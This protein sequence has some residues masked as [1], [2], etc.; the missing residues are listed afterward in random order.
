ML[1]DSCRSGTHSKKL[2]TGL[3]Q[4]VNSEI[5][6]ADIGKAGNIPWVLG[7]VESPE[8]SVREGCKLAQGAR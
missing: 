8:H 1:L 6:L 4:A 5:L 2:I 3:W 7:G